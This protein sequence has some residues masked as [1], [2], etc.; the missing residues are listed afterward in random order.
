MSVVTNVVLTFS[1]LEDDGHNDDWAEIISSINKYFDEQG[2]RGFIV[3]PREMDWYGGNKVLEAPLFVGAFNHLGLEDFIEHL[4]TIK[5]EYP[6]E[7]QLWVKEQEDDVFRTVFP[8]NPE[9]IEERYVIA[10]NIK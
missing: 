7:V 9:V 4:K 2:R 8:F 5:W 6:E 3:V 10:R 1:I